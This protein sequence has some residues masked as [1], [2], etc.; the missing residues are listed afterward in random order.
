MCPIWV[1]KHRCASQLLPA[2]YG[3]CSWAAY[4]G[5]LYPCSSL[6]SALFRFVLFAICAFFQESGRIYHA[7]RAPIRCST[8]FAILSFDGTFCR[9]GITRS[10]S[11]SH[12]G[13]LRQSIPEV[14][15]QALSN[16]TSGVTVHSVVAMIRTVLLIGQESWLLSIISY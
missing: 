15:V 4:R 5:T 8:S 9:N 1:L 10:S 13:A 3:N 16:G 6:I 7:L 12:C 11:S 14:Q 2:K